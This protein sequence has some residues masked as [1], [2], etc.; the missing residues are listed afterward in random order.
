[1]ENTLLISLSRQMALQH[2]IDVVANNVANINTTGFKG[3]GMLF[4]EYVMPKARAE[5]NNQLAP[6]SYVVDRAT[7]T[8][9]AAGSFETTGAEFDLAIQGG[10]FFAVQTPQGERYTR[11][12]AFTLNAQGDLVT[13]A[14]EKI[15]GTGGP[16]TFS[17]EDG[18]ITFGADG[19]IFTAQG[20]RGK[21]RVVSLKPGELKK[22]TET[23]FSS[24]GQAT[25]D[26]A[27]RILQGAVE[28]SNVKPVTEISRLIEINR[29]YNLVSQMVERTHALQQTAI[30]RLAQVS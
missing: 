18:K 15:L 30:E 21:I 1:M 2:E 17:V 19:T 9:L 22:E 23:L 11:A 10:G 24:K 28:K 6:V 12:G 4:N 14:G 3:D 27:S 26:T 13:P 29:T 20:Q 25:N 16:I 8:N 5:E 7:I